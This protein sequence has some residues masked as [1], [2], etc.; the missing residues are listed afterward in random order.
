MA[1]HDF[2]FSCVIRREDVPLLTR[3]SPSASHQW[4]RI[5][6]ATATSTRR[7]TRNPKKRELKASRFLLDLVEDQGGFELN[8]N[9]STSHAYS[10]M[11]L[12]SINLPM[13]ALSSNSPPSIPFNPPVRDLL[14]LLSNAP[15]SRFLPIRYRNTTSLSL[16]SLS[17]MPPFLSSPSSS[18]SSLSLSS[19]SVPPSLS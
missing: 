6:L 7:K 17:A 8:L 2:V 19:L 16:A 9:S 5:N 4:E 1:A 18:L 11:V 12:P 14:S 15:T 13:T 10:H 3:Q